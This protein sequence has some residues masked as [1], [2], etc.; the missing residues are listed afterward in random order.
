MAHKNSIDSC[1]N[2]VNG[3]KRFKVLSR[4]ELQHL[5]DNRYEA[6]FKPGEL[7]IKQDSPTSNLLFLSS[8]YAKVYIE[9]NNN[10]NFIVTIAK[11]G[12]LILGPG[13]YVN[14]RNTYTVSA[15]T[16]ARACF[17]SFDVFR[18][19]VRENALFA[20]SMIEE[21]SL[22]SLK[23]NERIVALAHKKMA[24]RLAD[25]LLF[26]SDEL[27]GSDEFEMLLSRQELGDM[28]N[29]AKEC[30]VR[31]FKE[32]EDDGLVSSVSSRISLLNKKRISEIS[33]KG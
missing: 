16:Q 23:S 27:F 20:E 8:G 6:S 18:T 15:L 21:V 26:F 25:A 4:S 9:G 28:T 32:F 24:G 11:P 14:S 19:L 13:A 3:W 33:E 12:Q 29:M 22:M 5:N 30:V 31:I 2:C 17:V 10:R 1:K 7:M